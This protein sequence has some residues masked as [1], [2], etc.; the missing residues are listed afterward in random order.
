MGGT[1]GAYSSIQCANDRVMAIVNEV[2]PELERIMNTTFTKCEAWWYKD[3]VVS[4]R[5]Y[6][7]FINT[8]AEYIIVHVYKHYSDPAQVGHV[9]R[10]M[11]FCSLP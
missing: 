4:G 2:R 1:P 3:Q 7:I 8:G 10:N 9:R 5:N 11:W 6:K